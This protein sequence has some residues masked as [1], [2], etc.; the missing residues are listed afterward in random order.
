MRSLALR[1]V[2]CFLGDLMVYSM[3]VLSAP[4]LRGHHARNGSVGAD[5]DELVHDGSVSLGKQTAIQNRVT[6][7]VVALQD[8]K[9]IS[10]AV[11]VIEAHFRLQ[12]EIECAEPAVAP[13]A[14]NLV[15]YGLGSFCSS[16]NAIYQLAY[17]KALVDALEAATDSTNSSFEIFDPVMNKVRTQDGGELFSTTV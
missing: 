6:Q 8:S 14:V 2:A 13:V 7:I 3:C 11:R 4:S 15:G 17:A 1:A 5:G 9:L 16:T 10:D 12:R